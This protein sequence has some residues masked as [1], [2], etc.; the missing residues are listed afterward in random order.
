[1]I[2][3]I[4]TIAVACL[5]LVSIGRAQ[6]PRPTLA[7]AS[8]HVTKMNSGKPV[9]CTATKVKINFGSG[10][11][12]GYC[13]AVLADLIKSWENGDDVAKQDVLVPADKMPAAPPAAYELKGD[14][15]GSS[16]AEYLQIHHDDCVS[17][18]AAAP[19]VHHSS[20]SGNTL[21]NAGG[22]HVN[23]FR[24]V[25]QNLDKSLNLGLQDFNNPVLVDAFAR[26]ISIAPTKTDQTL[27][28]ATAKMDREQLEFSQQRLYLIA[29]YFKHDWFELIQAAFINKFGPPTSTT[30]IVAKNLMGAQLPRTTLTWKN[31]IA[32][33]ELSEM[34]GDDLTKSQV[35]LVLDGVYEAVSHRHGGEMLNAVQK[36]M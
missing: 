2:S 3:K 15:L 21:Q 17:R 19:E 22:Q 1:M 28:L 13:Q 6:S 8:P 10:R 7:D 5:A 24:F 23:A 25:C 34:S 11:G 14:K 26:L 12:E 33:I 27:T 4:V 32:T 18:Y 20:F 36:D 16:M 30:E 29:Y 9:D 31:G 35:V